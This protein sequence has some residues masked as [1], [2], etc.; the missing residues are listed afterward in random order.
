MIVINV[1][2]RSL[3]AD[4][5]DTALSTDHFVPIGLAHAVR[6][7]EMACTGFDRSTRLAARRQPV[8]SRL[9][10]VP[11]RVGLDLPATAAVFV[12][13]RGFDT[14]THI[15]PLGYLALL[16]VLGCARPA[17]ALQA[18]THGLVRGESL[19]RLE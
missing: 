12:P 15:L 18:V 17:V 13:V 16:V 1:L 19:K 3:L 10:S 11:F 8:R 2:G 4:H 5:A 6:A 7:L 14:G 9:V